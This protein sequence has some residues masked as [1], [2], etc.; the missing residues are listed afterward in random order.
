MLDKNVWVLFDSVTQIQS[1]PLSQDQLQSAIY[2][3]QKTDFARFH[4]WTTGWE[5]WQGLNIFL[6]SEQS[7][8]IKDIET[9]KKLAEE[10]TVSRKPAKAEKSEITQTKSITKSATVIRLNDEH[11]KTSFKIKNTNPKFDGDNLTWSGAAPPTDLN[12]SKIKVTDYSNRAARH[13]LKIE[14]LLISAKGKTFRSHSKNISLTGTMLEDS[15]PFDYY[16]NIFDVVVV[17]RYADNPVNSRVQ[18][19][20]KTVGE[21][22]TARLQFE[23]V[24]ED[25]KRRLTTM[26]NEYIEKQKAQ[27]ASKKSA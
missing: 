13:E 7:V 1:Q 5:N 23:N 25:Q 17:N 10:K 21:G 16:G 24:T 8:F 4:I 20:A 18:L 11:T 22:L 9:A 6:D 27:A 2:K 3:M 14:I 26:L 12:F 15:A 19:K